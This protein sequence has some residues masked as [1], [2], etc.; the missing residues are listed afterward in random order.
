[1]AMCCNKCNIKQISDKQNPYKLPSNINSYMHLI[2]KYTL[3][4]SWKFNNI[5]TMHFRGNVVKCVWAT[6]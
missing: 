6:V 5:M 2:M 3:G 4:M 1:M